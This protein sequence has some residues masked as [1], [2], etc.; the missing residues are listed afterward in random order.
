M[1]ILDTIQRNMVCNPLWEEG[2]YKIRH[3]FGY[4]I[5]EHVSHGIGQE[6]TQFVPVEDS[7]KIS[8]LKLVNK[9]YKQRNLSVTYYIRPVLGV[10]DQFTAT[11]INTEINSQE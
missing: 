9:T 5:F 11:Q 7:V 10:S 6:M 3:G 1:Y 2:S 8:I 4:T